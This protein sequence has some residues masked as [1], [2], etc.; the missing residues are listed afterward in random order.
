M[1]LLVIGKKGRLAKYTPDPSMYAGFEISYVPMG[2]SDDE[3]LAAG[4]D[5]DFILVDAMGRV[6]GNVIEQM[7]NLK[8][9]HSEGVGYNF[10]D[11]EAAKKR[12][13]YVCNC[14]GMNA[15][16]VA[17]QTIL[18]MLG[19]LR[20]VVTGDRDVRA[21]K[22]IET[23]EAYMLAGNLTELGDCTIGLVG[24]GD[25][26]KET[27]RMAA[28]FGARVVYYKPVRASEELEKTYGVTYMGLDELLASSDIVSLHLP[29]TKDTR[30]MA[31]AG[32]LAKM[33]MGS[34][35]V[36]TSR[37]ELVDSAALLDAI[38][39][40]HL[41]GAGLDTIAG[42]P[43][44]ADNAVLQ[45][46]KDVADK[47]IFSCHIGGITASSFRRG[48]EMVWSDIQKA[49]AGEKPDHIVNPW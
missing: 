23:K 13:I 5:A 20:G 28:V 34:Y 6:S 16:A 2:A 41:A 15:A 44:Q 31:D 33:K 49:A 43:V 19:L 18:L 21:G 1:K 3:I 39:S 42:E 46:E 47:L 24:F 22:Q 7:P 29:V 11:V 40:G 9:I 10:I 25:I 45:A 32:F 14:K 27:A 12:R 37:G 48:Y 8:M 4:R 35:L 36:N 30:N 17:E 38:R 26:A